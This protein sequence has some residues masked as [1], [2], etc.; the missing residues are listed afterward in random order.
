MLL[1]STDPTESCIFEFTSNEYEVRVDLNPIHQPSD[2]KSQNSIKETHHHG[3]SHLIIEISRNEGILPLSNSESENLEI[4]RKHIDS[5]R[6]SY[7]N[8]CSKI[9]NRLIDFFKYKLHNPNLHQITQYDQAIQNPTWCINCEEKF[10]YNHGF[11]TAK[12][13][14]KPNEFGILYYSDDYCE[15][16]REAVQNGIETN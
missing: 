16:L 6:E 12:L 8:E 3:Y 5:V 14:P 2:S 1:L 7:I 9:C 11:S 15:P 13:L 10:P 4:I